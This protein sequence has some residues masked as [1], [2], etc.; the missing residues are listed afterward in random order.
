MMAFSACG[1]RSPGSLAFRPV[2]AS[3]QP[4]A[5]RVFIRMDSASSWRRLV[6]GLR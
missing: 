3:D 4:Q 6:E 5:L 2:M 1:L